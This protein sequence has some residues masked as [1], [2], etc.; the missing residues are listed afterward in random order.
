[1]GRMSHAGRLPL[2]DI[3]VKLN[4]VATSDFGNFLKPVLTQLPG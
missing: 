2:L 1:M 4:H 3:C